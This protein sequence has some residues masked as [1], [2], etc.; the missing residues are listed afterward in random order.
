MSTFD[1]LNSLG[2]NVNNNKIVDE[3]KE[4]EMKVFEVADLVVLLFYPLRHVYLL[5]FPSGTCFTR[6]I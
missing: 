2:N 3:A 4:T 5:L 1:E 6:Y